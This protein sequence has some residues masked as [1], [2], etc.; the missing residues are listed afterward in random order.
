MLQSSQTTLWGPTRGTQREQTTG[1]A[2]VFHCAPPR[3]AQMCTFSREQTPAAVA[4]MAWRWKEKQKWMVNYLTARNKFGRSASGSTPLT[5]ILSRARSVSPF[6][7][8][9]TESPPLDLPL[10]DLWIAAHSMAI[11]MTGRRTSPRSTVNVSVSRLGRLSDATPCKTSHRNY[12]PQE[13]WNS[14]KI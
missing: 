4:K 9:N 8:N 7:L 13:I 11:S 10:A 2:R 12:S 14:E 5:E 6:Q 3:E 1:S